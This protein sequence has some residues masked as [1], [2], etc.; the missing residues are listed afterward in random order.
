MGLVAIDDKAVKDHQYRMLAGYI[1]LLVALALYW[2]M[3]IKF[4]PLYTGSFQA[5]FWLMSWLQ[6]ILGVFSL[7]FGGIALWS[8]QEGSW[9]LHRRLGMFTF[10]SGST[11]SLISCLLIVMI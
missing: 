9:T 5:A 11:T 3:E 4:Y 6:R 7:I 2:A 8:V 10:L 1:S